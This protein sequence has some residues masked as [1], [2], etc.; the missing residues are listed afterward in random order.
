MTWLPRFSAADRGLSILLLFLCLMVFVVHPLNELA[1]V[2]PVMIGVSFSLL[3]ISGVGAVSRS[4]LA[5]AV[6]GALVL[7]NLAA[8]WMRL[9]FESTTL[10]VLDGFFGALFCGVT[11]II[12]LTEVF[13]EGAIT[14]NRIQG[15][16]AAYLLFG[17]F[18]AFGYELVAL[19]WPTAFASAS[20]VGVSPN[21]DLSSRFIYFSLV[22]LT[23]MGYGDITPV[24]P[25]ARSLATLEALVGQ[26]FPA[27]LLARLVSME[28]YHRQ[29]EGEQS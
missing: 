6:V 4:Q 25:I 9:S 28:L 17:L 10:P 11:A 8:R 5:R 12:V 14:L 3:L 7:A 24:H 29:S 15:A 2:G 13:R 20:P 22:T 1:A 26:L 21:E 16:I 23:T 19:R 27:I 18:W